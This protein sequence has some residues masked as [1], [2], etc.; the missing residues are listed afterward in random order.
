MLSDFERGKID[1]TLTQSKTCGKE[2][3]QSKIANNTKLIV[4]LPD[5]SLPTAVEQLID[6]TYI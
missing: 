6:E 4:Y 2:Y 1:R 3:I 5:S